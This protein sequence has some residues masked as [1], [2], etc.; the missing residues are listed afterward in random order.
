MRAPLAWLLLGAVSLVVIVGLAVNAALAAGTDRLGDPIDISHA[1]E[2]ATPTAPAPTP[3]PDAPSTG[4]PPL[5]PGTTGRQDP[6]PAPVA[7]EAPAPAPDW[8]DDSDDDDWDDDDW[9]DDDWD[10]DDWDD[11]DEWDDD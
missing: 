9:D 6:A 5:D 1:T 3:T 11:D 4:A 8:D 7:P 2:R 10:D